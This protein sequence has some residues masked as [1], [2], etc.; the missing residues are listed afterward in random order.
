M[1][2][3]GISVIG[4]LFLISPTKIAPQALD[5][6]DQ[7]RIDISRTY[8]SFSLGMSSNEVKDDLEQDN[9]FNYRGDPD[10]SLLQRPRESVIDTEGFL[11]ISRALFQFEEDSLIVIALELN[12]QRLDWYT[13]YSTLEDKYGTPSDLSP[14]KIIWEDTYTRLTM[15][16]PLTVKYLDRAAFSMAS[17]EI[18]NRKAWLAQARGEFLSEF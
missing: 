6:N 5:M 17:D 4:S 3:A 16:K 13:V 11:F 1:R 12:P 2:I 18:L 15:E 10:V 8:R 7:D 9:W 14:S